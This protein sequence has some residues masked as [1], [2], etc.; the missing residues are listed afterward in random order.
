MKESLVRLSQNLILVTIVTSTVAMTLFF[1]P[2]TTEFFEYNKFATVLVL[3]VIGFLLWSL[4]M[5]IDKRVVITRTPLDVPIILFLAVVLI[6]SVA[7]I[8]QFVSFFGI[9]GMVW[10][11]FFALALISALYFLTT[12]NFLTK[13][14]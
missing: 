10:P 3:T 5:F 12:S 7:S 8:D 6:S 2:T 14:N 11:S 9:H 1:L 13:K 4:K